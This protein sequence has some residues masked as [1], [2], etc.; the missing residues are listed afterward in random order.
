MG[1]EQAAERTGVP[2]RTIRYYIAE[3][4]LPGPAGRGKAASYSEEHLLRL[5]LIRRLAEQRLPLSEI[6][7]RLAGLGPDE[8][9]SLL[10]EEERRSDALAQAE[11]TASPREYISAL[12]SRAQ[13]ARQ[14]ERAVT[15]QPFVAAWAAVDADP[16][17]RA[18]LHFELAPGVEL[19]VRADAHG[20]H[21][22][23]IERL[24]KLAGATGKSP[25]AGPGRSSREEER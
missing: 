19:H 1:I 10:A 24:L 16:R 5:R 6:G 2:V 20:R 23:L 13:A 3:G 8:I 22:S 15:G 14:G 18:W 12:L 7:A 11:Q 4:L 17:A 25:R 21:R 9:R